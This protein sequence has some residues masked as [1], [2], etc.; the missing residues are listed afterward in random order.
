L[1][2]T[3]SWCLIYIETMLGVLKEKIIPILNLIKLTHQLD[4]AKV[5]NTKFLILPTYHSRKL[6][7]I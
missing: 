1:V 5:W 7:I 2:L 4:I 6:G 3:L